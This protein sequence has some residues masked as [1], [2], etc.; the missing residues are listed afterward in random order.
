M[1]YCYKCD[2]CLDR[3]QENHRCGDA[4]ASPACPQCGC[5]CTQRDW[6][7]EGGKVNA[8]QV[9]AN[10]KYPYVSSRLPTGLEGCPTDPKTGKTVVLSERHEREIMARHG[11]E[12]E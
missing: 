3:W 9:A 11:Y 10:Q 7:A 4:P 1:I 8:E 6:Q 2:D 12:R 5:T